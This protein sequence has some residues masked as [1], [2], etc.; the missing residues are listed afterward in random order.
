MD[1]NEREESR[2]ICEAATPG[3]WTVDTQ[4]Y[5][6]RPWPAVVKSASGEDVCTTQQHPRGLRWYWEGSY[7]D[8]PLIAHARTA[9]SAA[10]DEIDRL[11]NEVVVY[12]SHAVATKDMEIDRLERELAVLDRALD[13]A[14]ISHK[15]EKPDTDWEAYYIAKASAEMDEEA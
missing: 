5:L 4:E 7:P 11:E 2:R 10:L 13:M 15:C 8:A 14:L 3:P 6:L 12:L 1:R 9:L